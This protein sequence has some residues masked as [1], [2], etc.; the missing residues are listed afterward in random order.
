MEKR[1]GGFTALA[2][3]L[4]LFAVASTAHA[5]SVHATINGQDK[6]IGDLAASNGLQNNNPSAT[7]LTETGSFTLNA[8]YKGL[9]D[10]TTPCQF[11]WFQIVTAE[12]PQTTNYLGKKPTVPYTDPPFNGWDYQRNPKGNYTTGTPGDDQLPFYENNAEYAQDSRTNNLGH[13][14][15]DGKTVTFD[16]PEFVASQNIQFETYLTFF[17]PQLQANKQFIVLLGYSWG[18]TSGPADPVTGAFTLNYN[19]PAIINPA[20]FNLA[21]M[22]TALGNDGFAGWTPLNGNANNLVCVPEC[23]GVLVLT[24]CL[25]GFIIVAGCG[26]RRTARAS[27]A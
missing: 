10:D 15:T 16:A 18:G 1:T 13:N 22:T 4:M 21:N 20:G 24:V 5:I 17:N 26:S 11:R 9:M 25:L 23:P 6:I 19:G 12:T 14:V 27:I 8:T 3:T 7:S 2:V